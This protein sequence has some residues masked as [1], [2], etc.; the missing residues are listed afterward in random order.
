MVL[1]E[2]GQNAK[3]VLPYNWKRTL[4]K[5]GWGTVYLIITGLVVYFTDNPKWIALITDLM[6][7]QNFIKHKLGWI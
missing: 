7:V 1:L 6:A 5:F 4:E 3:I 2:T